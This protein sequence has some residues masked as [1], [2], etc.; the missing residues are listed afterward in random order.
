MSNN[1]SYSP[2][3]MYIGVGDDVKKIQGQLPSAVKPLH[4]QNRQSDMTSNNNQT[5]QRETPSRVT[6][7]P[8]PRPQ[9]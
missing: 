8:P 1:R 2:K 3:H 9:K 5:Y 6:T 4:H 7:P